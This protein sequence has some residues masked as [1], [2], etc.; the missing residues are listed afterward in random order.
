MGPRPTALFRGGAGQVFWMIYAIPS[1]EIYQPTGRIFWRAKPL[2]SL[3]FIWLPDRGNHARLPRDA[4]HVVGLSGLH[5]EG[6]KHSAS[7]TEKIKPRGRSPILEIP[8]ARDSFTE[9]RIWIVLKCVK[10]ITIA[11]IHIYIFFVFHVSG[12]ER[13]HSTSDRSC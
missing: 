13:E 4:V 1:D 10:V 2:P 5:R 6:F 8:L 9:L 11:I 7:R 3:G 12:I